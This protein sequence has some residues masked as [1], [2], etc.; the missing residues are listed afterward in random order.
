MWVRTFVVVS[1]S[2]AGVE[3]RASSLV[4]VAGNVVARQSQR[5]RA[6]RRESLEVL[7]AVGPGKGTQAKG[8]FQG[9]RRRSQSRHVAAS[10][11]VA[12]VPPAAPVMP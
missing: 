5:E 4:T 6:A 12:A 10:R 8:A 1:T 7:L 2:Y 11:N 3:A 9:L